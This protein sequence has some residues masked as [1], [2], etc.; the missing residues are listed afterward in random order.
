MQSSDVPMADDYFQN[1][2]CPSVSAFQQYKHEDLI[3]CYEKLLTDTRACTKKFKDQTETT[4]GFS[5]LDDGVLA[6]HTAR[7][8]L[9]VDKVI[10]ESQHNYFSNGIATSEI[11]LM[12]GHFTKATGLGLAEIQR[13]VREVSWC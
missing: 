4:F 11:L 13:S 9:T 10:F 3:G 5:L 2:A 7:Q 8:I 12:L 1:I 6:C